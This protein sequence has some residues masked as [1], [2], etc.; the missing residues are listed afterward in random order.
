MPTNAARIVGLDYGRA[1]AALFVL[2]WHEHFFGKGD[3]FNPDAKAPFL[4]TLVDVLNVNVL[5][6]AVPFFIFLSC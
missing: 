2:L 5:L 4:P 3:M 1:I 6:Q